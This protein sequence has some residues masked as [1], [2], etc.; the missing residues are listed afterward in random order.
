MKERRGDRQGR[1]HF[2]KSCGHLAKNPVL[3]HQLLSLK[4]FK[5]SRGG[6]FYLFSLDVHGCHK[7][8][9]LDRDGEEWGDSRNRKDLETHWQLVVS[10]I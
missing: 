7:D 8:H 3:L 5:Q 6:V 10:D 4:D 9:K 1:Q 2:V